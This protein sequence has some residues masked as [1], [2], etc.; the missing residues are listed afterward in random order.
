[1]NKPHRS[2]TSLADRFRR[3]GTALEE[4]KLLPF[5]TGNAIASLHALSIRTVEELL[6]L[7][8]ADIDAVAEFL[9]GVDLPQLQADGYQDANT[10]IMAEERAQ[11]NVSHPL[12][13]LQPL[14]V[15]TEEVA[16]PQTFLSYSTAA[17]RSEYPH[18]HS[19]VIHAC[20]LPA[21]DQGERGTCVAHA[22]AALLDCLYLTQ[23]SAHLNF[24]PQF[25]YWSAKQV[26]DHPDTEGTWLATA[27]P[28]TV[29]PGDCT[30]TSWPYNPNPN[31]ANVSQGPP[32]KA[33]IEEADRY[34]TATH[35][36]LYARS[37]VAIRQEIR[38]HFPVAISIP[39]YQNWEN[40]PATK[41]TGLIPM[42][43]PRSRLVGG[44]AVC[45]VGYQLDDQFTGGGAFIVRNSWGP[46]WAPL[47]PVQAGYGIIPF[48]YV[49]RYGWEAST[50]R[51]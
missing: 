2:E 29:K 14:N 4:T 31:P 19:E 24:S 51:L 48:E 38:N 6:G 39:V 47:S 23:R 22:T 5:L 46:G 40:N 28:T 34:R 13:A 15:E 8:Y 49:E 10:T 33:A 1:M 41:A 9:P 12:G 27:V 45:V 3:P 20:L 50:A 35:V 7:V 17:Q 26:D 44:H 32:P 18:D 25:I 21:R 36:E 43:L 30:E 16:D 37:P 11:Q 42:P